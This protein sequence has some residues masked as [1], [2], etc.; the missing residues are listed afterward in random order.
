MLTF[1]IETFRVQGGFSALFY[2]HYLYVNLHEI[3]DRF[4]SHNVF[5]PSCLLYE[6]FICIPQ[7][8][9]AESVNEPF[10]LYM[11]GG[12][13]SKKKLCENVFHSEEKNLMS[14][15]Y[16]HYGKSHYSKPKIPDKGSKPKSQSNMH[17][18]R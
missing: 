18:C 10:M 2:L 3:Y 11:A 14:I 1:S 8:V 5:F 6:T 13:G 7:Q 16:H 17:Y 12:V 15:S 4:S 9:F